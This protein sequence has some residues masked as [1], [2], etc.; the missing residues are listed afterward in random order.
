MDIRYRPKQGPRWGAQLAI[1]YG[2]QIDAGI[3]ASGTKVIDIATPF[4]KC[5]VMR[6][7]VVTTIVPAGSSTIIASVIHQN[8]AGA[9]AV[10]TGN[11]D[12]K[13]L[14]AQV[15]AEMAGLGG[16]INTPI[17]TDAHRFINEGD[18]LTVSVTSGGTVTTQP[19]GLIFVAEVAVIE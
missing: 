2:K 11:V 18:R 4:R 3:T 5:Y 6:L 16:N 13:A 8:L 12:L 17:I 15:V 7:S 14:T 1:L 19:V 10:L 9:V